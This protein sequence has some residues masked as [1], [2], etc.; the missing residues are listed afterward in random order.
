LRCFLAIELPKTTVLA[1]DAAARTIRD[2][3]AAWTGEKWVAPEVMHVTLKFL[4]DVDESRIDRLGSDF[5]AVA[6]QQTPFSL[7]MAGL[8][9]VPKPARASMI[10]AVIDDPSGG[11]LAQA[12][13]EVAA[14]RGFDPESRPYAP[15]VT[16]ARCRRPRTVA[17]EVLAEAARRSDL[18][19]LAPVSVLSATIF[20]STLTPLGPIHERLREFALRTE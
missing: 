2:L 3:D 17:S 11:G 19:A 6:A 8:R 15:H 7:R 1:L 4:G 13:D 10:W 20:A 14:A 9:G 18:A 5:A 12:L 16:L